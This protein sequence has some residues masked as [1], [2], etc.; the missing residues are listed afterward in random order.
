MRLNKLLAFSANQS[1]VS[2]RRDRYSGFS[3]GRNL[4]R[5]SRSTR[6]ASKS[7]SEQMFAQIPTVGS[8]RCV[9]TL[10]IL[11]IAAQFSLSAEWLLTARLVL[12]AY[13]I[14]RHIAVRGDLAGCI[15][16]ASI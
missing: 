5:R 13:T 10:G 12:A 14:H 11:R 2:F 4:S 6:E 16:G 15:S 3:V 8:Y 9:T 1:S 7:G